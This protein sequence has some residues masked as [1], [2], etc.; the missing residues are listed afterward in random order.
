MLISPCNMGST[1]V[2]H[3]FFRD[4]AVF[5]APWIIRQLRPESA[6]R[7][8]LLVFPDNAVNAHEV[9]LMSVDVQSVFCNQPL[10]PALCIALA[11]IIA[12]L[13]SSIIAYKAFRNHQTVG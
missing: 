12:L 13:V 2:G 10:V 5:M 7:D 9:F 4:F 1:T 6:L 3:T 11:T 8:L